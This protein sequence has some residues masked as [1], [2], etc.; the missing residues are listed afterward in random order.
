MKARIHL[1]QSHVYLTTDNSFEVGKDYVFSEV[2]EDMHLS[3]STCKTKDCVKV[4]A[5]NQYPLNNISPSDL[6]YLKERVG[7]EIE[8]EDFQ[9]E[10]GTEVGHYRS[11]V[12]PKLDESG[13]V[14]LKKE[15]NQPRV[16]V[17]GSEIENI[18][19]AWLKSGNENTTF[20][21]NQITGLIPQPTAASFTVEDMRKCFEAGGK[22]ID[23]NATIDLYWEYASFD[24]Y[25]KTLTHE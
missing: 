22:L 24:E 5:S 8:L 21:A 12:F 20:I 1:I 25:L 10:A 4:V 15:G 14:I 13:C 18:I 7:C 3:Y 23:C 6:P 19:I 2:G 17:A 9:F 11:D 16:D